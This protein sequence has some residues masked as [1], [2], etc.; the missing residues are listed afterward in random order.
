MNELSTPVASSP[1]V[2]PRPQAADQLRRIVLGPNED[3][4]LPYFLPHTPLVNLLPKKKPPSWIALGAISLITASSLI[5]VAA[6]GLNWATR[7]ADLEL[8]GVL[9]LTSDR[10]SQIQR[11]EQLQ[12]QVGAIEGQK[13]AYEFV[14]EGSPHW[15]EILD[16]LRNLLPA[17]V[18]FSRVDGDS[19]GT[20]LIRGTADSLKSVGSFMLNLRGSG[21]FYEPRLGMGDRMAA[22]GSGLVDYDLSVHITHGDW[23]ASSDGSTLSISPSVPGPSKPGSFKPKAEV[24]P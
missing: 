7:Q 5:G 1:A 18:H 23:L 2:V 3:Q 6:L 15:A 9:S 4:I 17:G 20:L 16:R 8:Q 19:S 24:A 22:S 11:Y 13:S 10:K 21:Y 12:H 14:T